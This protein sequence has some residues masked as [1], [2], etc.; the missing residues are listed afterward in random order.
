M[1]D[2]SLVLIFWGWCSLLQSWTWFWFWY[3]CDFGAQAFFINALWFKCVCHGKV[4]K[5]WMFGHHFLDYQ[6]CFCHLWQIWF[7]VIQLLWSTQ[8]PMF[9]LLLMLVKPDM[10]DLLLTTLLGLPMWY[11]CTNVVFCVPYTRLVGSHRRAAEGQPRRELG[12]PW[13]VR[14]STSPLLFL[15]T[16]GLRC[17]WVHTCLAAQVCL[18]KASKV[19]RKLG[20]VE[21]VRFTSQKA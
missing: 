1:F 3:F 8:L 19:L 4:D 7:V 13:V 16:C 5:C 2:M 18:E 12:S 14:V 10:F 11:F 15:S 9:E 20:H 21:C 6:L 17:H